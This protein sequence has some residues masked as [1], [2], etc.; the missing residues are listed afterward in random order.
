M[1][2]NV[3]DQPATKIVGDGNKAGDERREHSS[4]QAAP[5]VQTLGVQRVPSVLAMNRKRHA[6]QAGRKHRVHAS[7]ISEVNDVGVQLSQDRGETQGEET[8]A[9]NQSRKIYDFHI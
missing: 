2:P 3:I 7:P 8:I 1:N 9:R 4:N 5:K 6:G